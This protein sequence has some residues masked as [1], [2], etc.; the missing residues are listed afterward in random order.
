VA[1]VAVVLIAASLAA[2]DAKQ[3]AAHHAGGVSIFLSAM[4]DPG[5]LSAAHR[6]LAGDC[7]ACH[8]PFRGQ[9]AGKCVACHA[10]ERAV[11]ERQ[12][13]AFHAT[14]A[15]CS[16]CHVE[17]AGTAASITEM[18]HAALAVELAREANHPRGP[19]GPAP[20]ART[21]RGPTGVS[22]SELE[23][24]LDCNRCHAN[25]D[26]HRGLF[27]ADCAECHGTSGWK[28][29]GYRHPPQ[30]SRECAQCHLAPPSH[31]MM[32]FHMVSEMVVG[33][34]HVDVRRCFLCHQTTAWNDI[35]G[36]GWYKHH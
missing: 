26:K 9:D 1:S 5:A 8:T 2:S 28:V 3:T 25:Q 7:T 17:H 18:D 10:D 34:E 31:Y 32:H 15:R 24:G 14:I 35:R 6:N 21:G 16:G 4:T 12:P 19:D 33:L 22:A 13:T 20:A 27:G 30:D 23:R 36:V 11:L 29:D